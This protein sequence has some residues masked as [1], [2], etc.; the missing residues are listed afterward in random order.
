V[1]PSAVVLAGFAMWIVSAGC[2][3]PFVVL[4]G[5]ELE[6]ET[7]ATPEI[8]AFTD[9]ISTIQVETRPTDPYS[10]N[11]WAVGMDDY[12]YLHAGANRTTWI[13]YLEVDPLVRAR[14]DGTIYELRADKVEDAAEFARFADAY[15][16]KYGMRPRNEDIAEIY[17]YRL[18]AR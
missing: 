14:I 8:W 3:G 1:S 16:V 17:V 12:L 4:P 13:E 10:I 5:G 9:E 6:G 11:I 15:E 18:G 2:G 7:A